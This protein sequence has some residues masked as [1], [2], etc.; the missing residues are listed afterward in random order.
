MPSTTPRDNRIL[1]ALTSVDFERLAPALEYVHLDFKEVLRDCGESMTHVYFPTSALVSILQ[2]M[3]DGRHVEV[4]SV[5]RDG[6]AG[7]RSF[8]G[9]PR[10]Q[11]RFI[12]QVPGEAYRIDF[13]VFSRESQ[14]P[15]HLHDLLCRYTNVLLFQL[16][17]WVACSILHTVEQRC[18]RWLV[19]VRDRT[20]RDQFP[21]THEFLAQMLGVRRASVTEVARNLQRAG[22]ITYRRGEMTVRD[23]PALEKAACECYGRVKSEFRRLLP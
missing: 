18:C 3:E 17:Q 6:I 22:L 7:V 12:A 10:V 19:L 1:A 14:A 13:D 9:D 8:L 5:G 21:L 2:P 11:Q 4:A 20:G 23:L 15:G 16:S